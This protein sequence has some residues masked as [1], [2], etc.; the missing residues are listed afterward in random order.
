MVLP[1]PM[2]VSSDICALRDTNTEG[3][4]AHQSACQACWLSSQWLADTTNTMSG[5]AKALLECA[6][7]SL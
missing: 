3:S 7:M 5:N 2:H 4:L 6:L 1:A